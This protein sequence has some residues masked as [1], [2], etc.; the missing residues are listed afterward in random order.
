MA[1]VDV[2]GNSLELT[3][4]GDKVKAIGNIPV[5]G[6]D[7]SVWTD[8]TYDTISD[9]NGDEILDDNNEAIGGETAETLWTSRDGVGF[10]AT[11][12]E[13]DIDG[14]NIADT[15]VKKTDVIPPLADGG[16]LPDATIITVPNNAR[17]FLNTTKQTLSLVVNLAE[18]EVPNFALEIR[19]TQQAGIKVTAIYPNTSAVLKYS[20]AGGNIIE[21]NKDYQL[22]CVGTCWTVAEFKRPSDATYDFGALTITF[23]D[24]VGHAS[25]N[26]QGDY[27]KV[28]EPVLVE[29]FDYDREFQ[30]GV[31]ATIVFPFRLDDASKLTSG[32]LYE[33]ADIVYDSEKPGKFASILA[34]TPVTSIEPNHPYIYM[35]EETEFKIELDPGEQLLLVPTVDPVIT[36]STS[37]GD[38]LLHGTFRSST[39]GDQPGYDDS[40]KRFYGYVAEAKSGYEP[41]DFAL[42][43]GNATIL[44]MRAFF[45]RS[46]P[47][48]EEE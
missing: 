30:A 29:S 42:C 3:I 47:L 9:D 26:S 48:P 10:K 37:L 15:Y 36:L 33:V 18:D 28:T 13:A 44:L 14:N 11:R 24:D 6:G 39:I 7:E 17:S 20:D 43:S 5:G 32:K 45:E 1:D 16:F 8:E 4:E 40:D 25:V 2:N 31:T 23:E 46:F 27:I 22:T 19:T 38:W 12:A 34:S 41:G 35:P 21:A